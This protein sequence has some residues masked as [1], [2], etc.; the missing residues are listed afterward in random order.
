MRWNLCL[1][2]NLL[3]TGILHHVP[4][5]IAA[6]ALVAAAVLLVLPAPAGVPPQA[7]GA[8]ALTVFVI[9]FWATGALPAFI[10]TITF[11][12]FAM[13]FALAPANVVFAGFASTA[14]WLVFGGLVIGVGIERTGLGGRLAQS[15]VG[16]FGASYGRVILGLVLVGVVLAFLM[17]STLGR[18]VLLVPVVA[19][20]AD[21]LG[22]GYGSRGR[23]GMM[24]AMG[25]G[26]FMPSTAIL[27]ANLAN[28]VLL[29]T[30]ETI[31]GIHM[32]YVG[33]LVLHF[34]VLGFLKGAAIVALTTWLFREEPGPTPAAEARAPLSRDEKVLAVIL[35]LALVFW[36]TDFIHHISPA[37]IALAAGLACL[38]PGIDI[39]PARLFDERIQASTLI[40]VAGILGLAAVVAWSGLGDVL[41][42]GFIAQGGLAPGR[43]GSNFAV[44]FGL[45][46]LLGMATTIAG[47]PAILTP[48]AEDIAAASGLPLLTVLMTQVLGFST[49]ILPYQLP[50]LMIGMQLGGVPMTAGT[51]LTLPLAL[52]TV[53]VLM[54][55]DYLWWR[56]LGFL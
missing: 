41:A 34:P 28:M 39:I 21:R 29:G 47:I 5:V 19:S 20:F 22:F 32:T 42:H 45:S 46:T 11:F 17:P 44:L 38:L 50:P 26:T 30:S 15:L 7:M 1:G 12:A 40:Y 9:A 52:V 13:L 24:L 4:R 23:N 49:I 51:R 14:F 6:A 3:I 54:P 53:V 18:I 37:W 48:L 16:L 31:Y 36:S 43:P 35:A 33:Y 10:T 56:A 27:P 2:G 8:A 55:L 25:L